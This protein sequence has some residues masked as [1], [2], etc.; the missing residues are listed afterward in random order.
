MQL[1]VAFDAG[2]SEFDRRVRQVE[3][4]DAP[5]PCAEWTVRDLV[6]HVTAEH[7]WAPHLLRGIT[8]AE[9]GEQFDGDV[10]GPDPVAA[11]AA[12][13]VASQDAFHQRGAMAGQVHTSG[14]AINADEYAWQM[15]FDLTI[16]AWDLARGAGLDENLDPDLVTTITDEMSH[17][18]PVWYGTI[19]AP[20]AP[21]A[22]D[23]GP[24]DRLIAAT[25]RNP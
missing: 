17:Y 6:N 23:A 4:W 12:A 10:L 5:T 22:A 3:D 24:Q 11:W 9:I 14:G 7:L 25:G 16:H 18:F 19:L 20:P 1:I 15:V 2:L 13:A 8:L 21:V